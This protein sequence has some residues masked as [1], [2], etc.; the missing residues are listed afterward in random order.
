MSKINGRK[1]ELALYNYLKQQPKIKY[2]FR[3]NENRYQATPADLFI[4]TNK[5]NALIEVKATSSTIQRSNI[6]KSQLDSLKAFSESYPSNTSLL[7][8]VFGSDYYL[9]T[10]QRFG[11]IKVSRI[12]AEHIKQ[13]GGIHL[14]KEDNNGNR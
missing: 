9:I 5:G 11:N 13:A 10:V 4:V 12:T 8:L 7:C 3:F 14:F 1:A 2:I 6:R